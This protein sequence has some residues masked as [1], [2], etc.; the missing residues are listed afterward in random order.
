VKKA[1]TPDIKIFKLNNHHMPEQNVYLKE[2]EAISNA[3]NLKK[4]LVDHFSYMAQTEAD[5]KLLRMIMERVEKVVIEDRGK[6]GFEGE[7]CSMLKIFFKDEE[8]SLD[9][10]PPMINIPD[11]FPEDYKI[12]LRKHQTVS[13]NGSTVGEDESSNIDGYLEELGVLGEIGKEFANTEYLICPFNADGTHYLIYHPSKKR[14]DGSPQ[15]YYV[16]PHDLPEIKSLKN[17]EER[18]GTSFLH[19]LGY[20]L[21]FSF[22]EEENQ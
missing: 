5:F 21:G 11:H 1:I 18:V 4:A 9:A 3:K 12:C 14:K 20:Q 16:F 19:T 15:L 2:W 6:E 17:T 22:G 8:E 10:V 13:F 7:H